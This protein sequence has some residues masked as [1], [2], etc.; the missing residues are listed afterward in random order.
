MSIPFF[1]PPPVYV[2][3]LKLVNPITLTKLCK[4]AGVSCAA[5]GDWVNRKIDLIESNTFQVVCEP[6]DWSAVRIELP[7][8]KLEE[9]ARLALTALAY[10]LH[11]L[12]ARQSLKGAKWNTIVAPRGRPKLKAALSNRERQ[13]RFRIKSR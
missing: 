10:S 2:K 13:R 11:D 4:L 8:K 1:I 12:V 9:R 3:R 7:D 5:S 6:G